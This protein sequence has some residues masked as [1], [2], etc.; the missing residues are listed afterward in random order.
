MGREKAKGT[1]WETRIVN[2]LVHCGSTNAERRSLRGVADR[3]DIA[4]IIGV[5]IEAKNHGRV[6]MATFLDQVKAAMANAGTSIGFVWI[7]RRG[8]VGAEDGFVLMDGAIVVRLL[9]EAGYIPVP[10][11]AEG[12]AS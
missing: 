3:G 10:V 5:T 7:K 8:R 4:G 2:Y 11:P 9:Q 1:S 12:P 6:D